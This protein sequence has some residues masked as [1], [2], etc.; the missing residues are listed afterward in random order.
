MSIFNKG[1]RIVEGVIPA[2]QAAALVGQIEK[3]E[4]K[5]WFDRRMQVYGDADEARSRG[6]DDEFPPWGNEIAAAARPYAE[7]D[8]EQITIDEYLPGQGIPMHHDPQTFGP[9]V[10]I[11]TLAGN[12]AMRFRH[13]RTHPYF[14]DGLD[15]DEV[16]VLPVG[17]ML[18]LTGEA[19]SIWMH[20]VCRRRSTNESTRRISVQLHTFARRN[21]HDRR[22]EACRDSDPS[23]ST[24]RG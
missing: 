1:A 23:S 15:D 11:V 6:A 13:A 19:R 21:R 9:T 4:W 12:W 16:A 18:V 3:R 8:A 24:E 10:L 14:R 17:S 5:P 20:G 22:L 2:E 7:A